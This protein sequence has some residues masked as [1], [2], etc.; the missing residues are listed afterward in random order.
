MISSSTVR[1]VAAAAVHGYTALGC[2]A[3]VFAL[4]AAGRRNFETA[5]LLLFVATMIDYSDGTLA[6][7]VDASRIFTWVDGAALD[8]LVDFVANIVAPIV[9]LIHAD[10]W[11]EPGWLWTT[12]VVVPSL[13][14]FVLRNPY[15]TAGFFLGIPPVLT[16]PA[17]YIYALHLP[18]Y[19]VMVVAVLYCIFCFVPLGYVHITRF[20]K[21]AVQHGLALLGW[22]AIYL[23]VTQQWTSNGRMLTLLSLVYVLYYLATS[24]RHFRAYMRSQSIYTT[25][26]APLNREE[27]KS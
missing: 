10:L 5:F 27:M 12:I 21:H 14:R 1:R 25:G 13:Y 20:R 11:P 26:S 24:V 6:R 22:W 9:L 17:F 4:I 8:S 15:R 7:A 16:L 3:A 19:A 23:I 2:V 18:R